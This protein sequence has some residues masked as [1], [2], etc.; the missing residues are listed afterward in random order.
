MEF[1]GKLY[2]FD[3]MTLDVI[4]KKN[5]LGQVPYMFMFEIVKILYLVACDLNLEI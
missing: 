5:V 2:A 4:V 1:N 3:C